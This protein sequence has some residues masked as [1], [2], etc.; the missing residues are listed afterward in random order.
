MI[1]RALILS[2]LTLAGGA[3]LA[4]SASAQEVDLHVG[5]RI[6]PAALRVSLPIGRSAIRG[7]GHGDR[8]YER[9]S[10]RTYEKRVWVP[11]SYRKVWVEPAYETR[12]DACGRRYRVLVRE[13][14][15][16]TV[17]EPG[18][19]ETVVVHR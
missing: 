19:W 1:S 13:G 9:C 8:R 6:G 14:H 7:H 2:V 10:P 5:A 18:R 11:A 12:Y 16:R 17:H 4:P 15:W 3:G